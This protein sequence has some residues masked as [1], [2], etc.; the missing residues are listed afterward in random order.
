M[1]CIRRRWISDKYDVKDRS[2]HRRC[3]VR[4]GVVRNFAKFTGKHPCQSLF[5]NEVAGLARNFIKKETLEQMFSCE[6][7]KF[8]RTVFLQNTFG[9]CLWK[10]ENVVCLTHFMPR[11]FFYTSRKHRKTSSSGVFRGYS[12]DQWRKMGLTGYGCLENCGYGRRC[13]MNIKGCF[14]IIVNNLENKPMKWV[15]LAISMGYPIFLRAEI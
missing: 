1:L 2:S 5:F 9:G 11:I 12:R 4:K 14:V 10:D 8:V 13:S 3:S 7:C 6:F 15:Y